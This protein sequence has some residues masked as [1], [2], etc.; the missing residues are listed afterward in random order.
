MKREL[1]RILNSVS[2]SNESRPFKG[3]S[4]QNDGGQAK[5]KNTN[6]PEN[7]TVFLIHIE[8]LCTM[9]FLSDKYEL[10]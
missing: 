8:D 5:R 1:C 4:L 2:M 7:K 9:R 10:D 3:V 6:P